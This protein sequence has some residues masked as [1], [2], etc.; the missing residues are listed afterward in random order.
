MPTVNYLG[1]LIAA[2]ASMVVAGIWFTGIFSKPW[3]RETGK[4]EEELKKGTKT[5]LIVSFILA[6]VMAYAL[7]VVM[8]F[9]NA[10]TA[11]EVLPIAFLVW[12]GFV[13]ATSGQ[14][15]VTALRSRKLFF[16]NNF[17]QLVS[18]V[19]MGLILLRWG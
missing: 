12:L 6:L 8:K 13:I 18:L 11:G 7:G 10:D 16:I 17:Y 15:Y 19:V 2:I 4:S 5:G 9:A 14:D 1:V 3:K